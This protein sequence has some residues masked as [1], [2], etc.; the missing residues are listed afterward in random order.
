MRCEDSEW[1]MGD[2]TPD[3]P[4]F[5]DPRLSAPWPPGRAS[6]LGKALAKAA[7]QRQP[8]RSQTSRS[9]GREQVEIRYGLRPSLLSTCLQSKRRKIKQN[10]PLSKLIHSCW[11]KT[12]QPALAQYW[13]GRVAQYSIGADIREITVIKCL[14]IHINQ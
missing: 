2:L 14:F 11:F 6:R 5:P 12:Q 8:H 1:E 9:E 13:I 7:W 4:D 10:Q 3:F